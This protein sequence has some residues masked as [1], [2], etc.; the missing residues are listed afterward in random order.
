MQAHNTQHNKI[1][2]LEANLLKTACADLKI[3][4]RLQP[5]NKDEA[6]MDAR[7]RVFCRTVSQR[8]SI[9][10]SLTLTHHLKL[11]LQSINMKTK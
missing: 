5:V 2:D 7:A 10:D 3:V 4:P 9:S 8:F 11:T 6:R 1:R